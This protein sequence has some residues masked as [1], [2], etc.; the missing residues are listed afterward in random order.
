[1]TSQDTSN[2]ATYDHILSHRVRAFERGTYGDQG[3]HQG[4]AAS[5]ETCGAVTFGGFASKSDARNSLVHRTGPG[6]HL[7]RSLPGE[8]ADQLANKYGLPPKER[9]ELQKR[10]LG[11]TTSE[12]MQ[13]IGELH[14]KHRK[15]GPAK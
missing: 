5:C 11:A 7:T 14:R 9:F 3:Q 13:I 2:S 4:Y 12:E 6:V 10:L 1:M 8:L 15:A